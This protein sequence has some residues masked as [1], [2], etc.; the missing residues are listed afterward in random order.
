MHPPLPIR[1]P[2]DLPRRLQGGQDGLKKAQTYLRDMAPTSSQTLQASPRG[3]RQP[4]STPHQACERS[5]EGAYFYHL[6]GCIIR[7]RRTILRKDKRNVT[8]PAPSCG[9]HLAARP[10]R[11]QLKSQIFISASKQFATLQYLEE[12][13]SSQST[14]VRSY[15]KV[16]L[17]VS[18]N[19]RDPLGPEASFQRPR[20]T[21]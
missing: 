14:E 1:A 19:A 15:Q 17:D 7:S 9:G 21:P 4:T 11:R 13:S 2:D 12:L 3:P 6:E 5:Q 20:I 18:G 10:R 16:G 8:S